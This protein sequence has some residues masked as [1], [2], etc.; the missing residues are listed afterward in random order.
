[1]TYSLL[2]GLRPVH[3]GEVL[4]EIV[5]PALGLSKAK[6]AGHL[7]VIASAEFAKH[8]HRGTVKV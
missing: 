4:R 7:G 8:R 5:A 2:A 1:M 3:P 6:I